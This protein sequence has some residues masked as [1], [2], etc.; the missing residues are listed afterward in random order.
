MKINAEE[1]G[2]YFKKVNEDIVEFG[3]HTTYVTEEIDFTPFG[4]STGIYKNFK[5]PELFISGLPFNLTG[6]LIKSYVEKYKFGTVPVHKKTNELTN[7]FP[8]Y[9]TKV[10][11]KNLTEYILSTIKFYDVEKFECVQLIIPDLNG[12][13]PNEIDYDYD[14]KIFGNIL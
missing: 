9:F 6:E 7:R 14:Q 12:N 11:N 4:Y 10:E 2:E 5:I 13:F 1:K 3:Y 8:V